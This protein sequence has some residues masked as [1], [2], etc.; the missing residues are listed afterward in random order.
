[1]DTIPFIKPSFPDPELIKNDISE[2][3]KSNWY[4]NSGPY[5]QRLTRGVEEY[6]GNGV[7]AA[8]VCNATIALMMAIKHMFLENRKKVLIQSFTFAAGPHAIRWCGFEPVFFDVV[9]DTMQ[10]DITQ[11]D[12]YLRGNSE[13]VA[14]ILLCNTFGVPNNNIE[15]WENLAQEYKL[16]L[17]IDSAAGFGATYLN[18]DRMGSRGDCEIFS[19][20]ATKPF[21]IGE[22]G[23]IVSKNV[24]LIEEFNK[25]K[26]FSFGHEKT[27]E[28]LGLNAKV[29]EIT[30][31]FGVRALEVFDARLVKRRNVLAEYRKKLDGKSVKFLPNEELSAVSYMTIMVDG[32]RDE[33][34]SRFA[35][36]N[37]VVNKYYNPPIHLHPFFSDCEKISE[38]K[39]TDYIYSNV[40]S[41]PVH[42]DLDSA[43]IDRITSLVY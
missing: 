2:I 1:M 19:F 36:N 33:I 16:P 34:M 17:L 27:A 23:A 25:M 6:I 20:H 26:N 11:V 28:F 21:G 9:L 13:D 43:S 10:P 18:G 15:D 42:D 31:A 39:N 7:R 32:N 5:E 35:E 12:E 38:L 24:K 14:G 41:L 3:Y 40:I 22:G 8:I 4:S 37:I 29:D 30:S